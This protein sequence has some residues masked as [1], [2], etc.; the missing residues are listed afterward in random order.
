MK[1]SE[2]SGHAVRTIACPPDR[3]RK[4]FI[5]VVNRIKLQVQWRRL[6]SKDPDGD[7]L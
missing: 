3:L 1:R 7:P 2:R 4:V 6:R 5:G